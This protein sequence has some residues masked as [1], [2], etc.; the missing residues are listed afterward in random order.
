[1]PWALQLL[2]F[3]TVLCTSCQL[4]L[5]QSLD[6][7]LIELAI[8]CFGVSF[9]TFPLQLLFHFSFPPLFTPSSSLPF[10][11]SPSL[12]PSTP[13]S[14]SLPLSL[15]FYLPLSFLL[16]PS[17]S[18]STPLP[19]PLLPSL[20]PST[21][22]SLSLSSVIFGVLATLGCHA[23]LAFGGGATFIPFLAMVHN[24]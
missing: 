22:L 2:T 6:L 12:F 10:H 13:L 8:I 18:P 23:A 16:P 5:H 24:E 11:P 1:M 14:P 4:L 9:D 20:S 3:V 7:L 21:L 15:P 17:F 19:P